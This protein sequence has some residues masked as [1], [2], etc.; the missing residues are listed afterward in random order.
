MNEYAKP[1]K[2]RTSL[3][4]SPLWGHDL[5]WSGPA[6]VGLLALGALASR[7]GVRPSGSTIGGV[8]PVRWTG[9]CEQFVASG[10]FDQVRLPK[11]AGQVRTTEGLIG[12]LRSVADGLELV[13]TGYA[14]PR[15]PRAVSSLLRHAR[16]DAG[17]RRFVERACH[18]LVAGSR[19]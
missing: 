6:P 11:R 13:I 12:R 3:L 9:S 19:Q 4:S 18:G 2:G 14:M 10:L 5:T 1:S 8:D 7:A 16:A 17:F 15:S